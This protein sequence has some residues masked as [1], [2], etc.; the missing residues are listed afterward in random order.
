MR[1]S[2][3]FASVMLAASLL[4]Q[5][6]QVRAQNT[7]HDSGVQTV[8]TRNSTERLEVA[9]SAFPAPEL[10][11]PMPTPRKADSMEFAF[12]QP[13]GASVAPSEST[14]VFWDRE[15]RILFAVAGGFAAADFCVTRANLASGG[16]ELN[17]ITRV[18]SGST[19]GLAAN[20]ALE[21][22]GLIGINYLFHKTGHHKLERMAS[23]VNIGGSAGAVAFGLSH[24]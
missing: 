21:T 20:F 14:H 2:L 12:V 9:S 5:P 15:N 17:P 23:F 4:V 3:N 10:D 1:L 19:P 24:R 6:R 16:R 22:G 7:L 11:A 18:L 13:V 8:E